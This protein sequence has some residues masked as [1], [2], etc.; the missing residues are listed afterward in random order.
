MQRESSNITPAKQR[1]F[2]KM[3]GGVTKEYETKRVEKLLLDD[4]VNSTN[5]NIVASE[6]SVCTSANKYE[7]DHLKDIYKVDKLRPNNQLISSSVL[8][9][10]AHHKRSYL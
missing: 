10:D 9:T 5:H 8:N 4:S 1:V 3:A 6:A 2:K 7:R